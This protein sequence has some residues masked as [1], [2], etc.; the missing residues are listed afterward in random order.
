MVA[1]DEYAR[2]AFPYSC[3]VKCQQLILLDYGIYVREADLCGI[4]KDNGWYNEAEGMFMCD[5]GKLL[6]CFGV[7]YHHRQ[8]CSIDDMT[9]ELSLEHRVMANVNPD[10]LHYAPSESFRNHIASHSVLIRGVDIKN[11]NIFIIDPMSGNIDETCPIEWFI[12]A[13][14]DSLFYM[15]STNTAAL[16]C[17]DPMSKTMKPQTLK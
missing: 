9:T 7:D 12:H 4:A 2:Q 14:A 1:D 13:W 16:Y 11:E 8:H 17:Y 15:L 3:A 10:K 5:N 6:G